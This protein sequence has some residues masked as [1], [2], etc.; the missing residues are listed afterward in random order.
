MSGLV[1]VVYA[2]RD[3]DSEILDAID[4]VLGAKSE[5]LRRTRKGRV[6]DCQIGGRPIHV[7]IEET[8]ERFWDCEDDLLRLGLKPSD[9]PFRVVLTAACHEA[10]DREI[11]A[12][13]VQ[14]VSQSV[15]GVSIPSELG[16]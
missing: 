16:S 1:S 6:W 3:L 5:S 7:A 4:E 2:R 8:S 14:K 11:I 13:L 12:S 9:A 10:E 15:N